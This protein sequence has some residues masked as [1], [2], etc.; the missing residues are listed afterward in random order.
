M[1]HI[2][3]QAR[4]V[5]TLLDQLLP[6]GCILCDQVTIPARAT[7]LC[8]SCQRA[9]PYNQPSCTHCA[10]PLP[11]NRHS[12]CGPC[13]KSPVPVDRCVV[14]LLHDELTQY[15]V[16]RLKFHKGFREAHSLGAI[17]A[18][19]VA[20]DYA[21]DDVPQL[22]IPVPLAYWK[23]V[24]RGYNQSYELAKRV[25]RQLD[26]RVAA[27]AVARRPGPSQR[28]LS[29]T[30][31]RR[32]KLRT[33]RIRRPIRAIHVAIID[34]VMTTGTTVST[35]AKVLRASGVERVDAWCATRAV[36]S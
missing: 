24:K 29:R 34:D 18:D 8:D 32:L 20:R 23:A 30:E 13:Q 35:L 28:D 2:C 21:N 4:L 14:P 17:I 25:G 3:V 31:R 9:L 26:I 12:V 33:F 6:D 36:L 1:L 10:L 15:L 11:S 16:H 5:N 22:L 19:A 7:R 27:N